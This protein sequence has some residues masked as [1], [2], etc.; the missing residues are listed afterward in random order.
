MNYSIVV[1]DDHEAVSKAISGMF[2]SKAYQV[3][4]SKS[5]KEL[6]SLLKKNRMIY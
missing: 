2:E 5:S 3:A 4:T 6:L 1:L